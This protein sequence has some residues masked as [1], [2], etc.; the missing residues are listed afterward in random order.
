MKV[1]GFPFCFLETAPFTT[2]GRKEKELITLLLT[3][4]LAAIEQKTFHC[5]QFYQKNNIWAI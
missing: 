1:E 3:R 2:H 5:S 4:L